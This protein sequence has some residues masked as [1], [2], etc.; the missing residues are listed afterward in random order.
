MA[1][2]QS[3]AFGRGP[4]QSGAADRGSCENS[5]RIVTLNEAMRSEESPLL[6]DQIRLDFS[7]R[8]CPVDGVMGYR[9]RAWQSLTKACTAHSNGMSG[10]R[11]SAWSLFGGDIVRTPL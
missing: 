6:S 1:V 10:I 5:L 4:D 11:E 9:L 7:L 8:Y 2:S 3:Y